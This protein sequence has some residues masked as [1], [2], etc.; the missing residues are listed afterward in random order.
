MTTGRIVYG[1]RCT[2]W[3][4]IEEAARALNDLPCCPHCHGALFEIAT[5]TW[6][7]GLSAFEVVAS[8]YTAY[9]IWLTQQPRCW[10]RHQQAIRAYRTANP[11]LD[12]DTD[13]WLRAAVA[14]EEPVV[15]RPVYL[16]DGL[17]A[18]FENLQIILMTNDPQHPTDT[19]CIEY[20]DVYEALRKFVAQSVVR[21]VA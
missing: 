18:K 12:I 3:G 15:L 8:G 17:Y 21:S 7:Q 4:Q 14:P 11:T 16:G 2:W 13:A 5:E 19:M 10:P 1:A 20:P 6:W 9:L